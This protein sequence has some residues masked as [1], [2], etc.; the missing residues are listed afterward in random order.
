MRIKYLRV[1]D[2]L[3]VFVLFP[4]LLGFLGVRFVRRVF[5]LSV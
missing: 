1:S 5:R 3:G 4:I 2:V